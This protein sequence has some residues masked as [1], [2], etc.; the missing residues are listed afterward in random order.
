MASLSDRVSNFFGLSTETLSNLSK[1]KKKPTQP[2]PRPDPRP[3]KTDPII[4][5]NFR[6]GLGLARQ[7]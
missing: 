6:V 2:N 5:P 1:K 7:T 4:D 3:N